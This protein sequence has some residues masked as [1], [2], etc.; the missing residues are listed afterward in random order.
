MFANQYMFENTEEYTVNTEQSIAHSKPT[1]GDLLRSSEPYLQAMDLVYDAKNGVNKAMLMKARWLEAYVPQLIEIY[2]EST[3]VVDQIPEFLSSRRVRSAEIKCI[4]VLSSGSIWSSK[5]AEKLI[6]AIVSEVHVETLS[7]SAALNL[8]SHLSTIRDL[9]QLAGAGSWTEIGP[10]ENE[11]SV[12]SKSNIVV[13]LS[14]LYY[15]ESKTL[16]K[17]TET[18]RSAVEQL[19]TNGEARYGELPALVLLRWAI[20]TGFLQQHAAEIE[21]YL[22]ARQVKK[23]RTYG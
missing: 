13:T 14:L 9:G 7:Q 5:Y 11:I 3:I 2:M 1:V 15:Y 19:I 21:A 4:S 17:P 20:A 16:G 18:T 12:S 6:F 10:Y 8:A 23:C 22:A